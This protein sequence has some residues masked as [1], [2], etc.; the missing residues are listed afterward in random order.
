MLSFYLPF[1]HLVLIAL[2][3]LKQYVSVMIDSVKYKKLM[4]GI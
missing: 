1:I 2:A 4:Q 3:F